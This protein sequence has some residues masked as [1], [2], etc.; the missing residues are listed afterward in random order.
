MLRFDGGF[1]DRINIFITFLK[2]L[3]EIFLIHFH[4][5]MVDCQGLETSYFLPRRFLT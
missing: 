4:L 3:S 5:H 2:V 1:W